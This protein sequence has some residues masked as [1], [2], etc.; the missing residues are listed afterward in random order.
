LYRLFDTEIAIEIALMIHLL[1]A[2]Y[3][4]WL[5]CRTLG[6]TAIG[7]LGAALTFGWSGWMEHCF[8]WPTLFYGMSWLP[9]TVLLT[10]KTLR[11]S[12]VAPFGLT[13]AVAC[14][15]LVGSTEYVLYNGYVTALFVIVRVAQLVREQGRVICAKRGLLL[16]GSVAA[17]VALTAAQ[18]FPTV[19]LFQQSARSAP[20]TLSAALGTGGSIPPAK[21]L[22]AGLEDKGRV[23][24]GFVPFIGI[25]LGLGSKR[26]Q[27]LW[28][29]SVALVVFSALWVFGDT[30]F[31]FYYDSPIGHFFRRPVKFLHVYAFSQSLIAGIALTRLEHW[32]SLSVRELWLSP[33]WLI[34]V[35][36][37]V[38]G[39]AW[40]GY[41]SATNL[42]LIGGAGLLLCFGLSPGAT[43]RQAVVVMLFL[44]QGVT[45]FCRVDYPI[46]RPFRQAGVFDV[47]ATLLERFGERA[48][49]ARIYISPKGFWL[50][51]GLAQ[52]QGMMRGIHV[53]GD[54][55]PLAPERYR[56][57]FSR[58]AGKELPST[59]SG[60]YDLGGQVNWRLMDLTGTRFYL[61]P[62][63]QHF[64]F[65][66]PRR[67]PATG[68][69]LVHDSAI[70]VYE[71]SSALP[72]AY[73]V[74]TARVFETA[75]AALRE[76]E[77]PGFDPRNEV[78]L[79]AQLGL[80]LA[81]ARVG[82]RGKAAEI[83]EYDS[84][85]VVVRA[86]ASQAGFL[87]LTDAYYPGWTARVN[88]RKVPIYQANYLFRA[89]PVEPGRAEVTFEYRPQSLM[90]GL[91]TSGA[92]AIGLL[93]VG[94]R[95]IRKH[96]TSLGKSQV[97]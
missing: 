22:L 11:G 93:I 9:L 45:L 38:G 25:A 24:V 54:Y 66:M 90:Y 78:V 97:K 92:A 50:K 47:Q 7:C 83:R 74:P 13:V 20:L 18:L 42:Y 34:T 69:R 10:E 49:R 73:Y 88:G 26:L 19:E 52:K 82:S 29:F 44:M 79:E 96:V 40:L 15:L 28:L 57:F 14:Q 27:G 2:S 61:V 46:F 35:S 3:T 80:D 30:V 68:L 60:A 21:F 76:L 8:Q 86:E 71:R 89:V 70:Q 95:A 58:A 37:V 75:E 53:V 67:F 36:C 81:K 51:P 55:E 4:M 62:R 65:R 77:A 56:V 6:L 5:L 32:R 64:Q 23:A 16:L 39:I 85:R 72:R 12:A 41:H 94:L 33:A 17:G 63:K 43:I 48:D 59:F 1:F 87:V 91:W 31:S 84:W